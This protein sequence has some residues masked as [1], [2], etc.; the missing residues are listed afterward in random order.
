MDTEDLLSIPF[1][2]L[3]I[4]IVITMIMTG[5]AEY[6]AGRTGPGPTHTSPYD[7]PMERAGVLEHAPSRA[8]PSPAREV[9]WK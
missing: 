4:F 7:S 2:A 8:W 6:P 9:P 1:V 3:M 5:I